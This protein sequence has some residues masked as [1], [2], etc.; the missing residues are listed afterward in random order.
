MLH[1]LP[2]PKAPWNQVCHEAPRLDHAAMPKASPHTVAG[3]QAL[4]SLRPPMTAGKPAANPKAVMRRRMPPVKMRM[5]R[6]M[7]MMLRS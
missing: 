3:N 2:S 7:R 6:F 4:P 1:L 5:W